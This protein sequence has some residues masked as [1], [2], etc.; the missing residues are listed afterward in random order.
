MQ[1]I[2]NE[3]K[4][5]SSPPLPALPKGKSTRLTVL[6]SAII[7]ASTLLFLAIATPHSLGNRLTLW[8]GHEPPEQGSGSPFRAEGDEYLLGV[9]K[10]D[11]TGYAIDETFC[12][13]YRSIN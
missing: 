13:H 3:K 4:A 7:F 10:A 9:G 6:V 2:D 1:D 5:G 12:V 8:L 11:I